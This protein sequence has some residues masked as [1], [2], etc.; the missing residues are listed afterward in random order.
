MWVGDLFTGVHRVVCGYG[1][2]CQ[3]TAGRD[4][5]TA[6]TVKAQRLAETRTAVAHS[7]GA[8][9][10]HGGCGRQSERWRHQGSPR[11]DRMYSFALGQ[12]KDGEGAV[13][14]SGRQ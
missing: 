14:G 7:H 1:S 9:F 3:R 2:V 11:R 12:L 6:A 5:K 4:K 8:G 13:D 10:A